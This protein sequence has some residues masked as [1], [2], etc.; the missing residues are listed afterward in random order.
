M[1]N[2]QLNPPTAKQ[3]SFL[4]RRAAETGQTFSWPETF[5]EADAQIKCA[6]K[7]QRPSSDDLRRET[8]A[9]RSE[10]AKRRGG[11]AAVREEE[12][13]GYGSTATWHRTVE[14]DAD[15]QDPAWG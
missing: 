1:T 7:R 4:R 2:S 9:V 8:A 11:A 14:D 13:C 3:L 10:M 12:L 15:E 5:A 6:L